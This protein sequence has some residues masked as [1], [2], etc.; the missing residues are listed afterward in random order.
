L[1]LQLPGLLSGLPGV[2]LADVER[3]MRDF[4][5]QLDE[6]G[7]SLA[8]HRDQTGLYLWLIAGTTAV[9][10]CEMARRQLR[11]KKETGPLA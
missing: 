4:L 1:L 6:M 3:G 2:Q 10:A 11:V 8:E 9:A 7:Q 5:E